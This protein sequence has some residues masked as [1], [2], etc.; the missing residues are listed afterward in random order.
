MRYDLVVIG[1]DPAGLNGAIAAAKLNKRVAV[2]EPRRLGTRGESL[3]SGAIRSK[4]IRDSLV[5]LTGIQQRG[6]TVDS[7]HNVRQE[8]M[9]DWKQ[10]VA[11]AVDRECDLVRRQLDRQG[12]ALFCGEASFTDPHELIVEATEGSIR[13]TA[14]Y[15]LVACG[16]RPARPSQVPFDGRR[17]FDTDE[18]LHIETLPQSLIVV[19]GGVIG[20]ECA[21]MFSMLGVHV[22]VI[23]GR[24]RILEF[25]DREIV[26]VLLLHGRSWGIEF[27]LGEDVIGIDHLPGDRV[28]VQ[29]ESGKRLIGNA[30][31]YAAGN[32]GDTAQLN[33]EAAGLELDDRGRLWCDENHRTW[34]PH[35]Y[36]AGDVV[37]FPSLASVSLDQGRGAVCHAYGRPLP[38]GTPSPCA[39]DT[40]PEISMVGQN[41]EQLTNKRVP[42][43]VG[44]ARVHEIARR[45]LAGDQPGLLKILFHRA[46]RKLLGVHCIGE[47]ASEI[48]RIGQSATARN[49]TIDDFC[50]ME[51]DVP[52]VAE[53][54][55]LAALDGLSKLRID[56]D[57]GRPTGLK[58]APAADA[59]RLREATAA[60][61]TV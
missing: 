35:I 24:A 2:V 45:Q 53:C 21:M 60:L 29:L 19:G 32:V 27:R 26:D 52:T 4:A 5:H 3:R 33:L 61:A 1:N 20:L 38:V 28:A 41:E 14:D 42:Y 10:K 30:V 13:L 36:G 23:D 37:G 11:S 15:F 8:T 16:T 9:R 18:I 51:F 56:G 49:G 40:I 22:T 7:E 34:A 17:V 59:L 6:G 25:C 57:A 31:L 12:I 46:T 50:N 44:V 54:Y 58:L 43:E 55:E 39:L 48:I 47:M